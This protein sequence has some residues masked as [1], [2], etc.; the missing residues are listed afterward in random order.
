MNEIRHCLFIQHGKQTCHTFN[1]SMKL[2]PFI[3]NDTSQHSFVAMVLLCVFSQNRLEIRR[4][5]SCFFLRSYGS[6]QHMKRKNQ[7]QQETRFMFHSFTQQSVERLQIS[8]TFK[9]YI[10]KTTTEKHCF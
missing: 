6:L 9:D 1:G 5:F 3:G 7:Q 8:I 4:G 2:P 10:K